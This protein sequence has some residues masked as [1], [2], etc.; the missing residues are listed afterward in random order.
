[1]HCKYC[2]TSIPSTTKWC[3]NGGS[4]ARSEQ[5][6]FLKDFNKNSGWD[7]YSNKNTSM[8]KREKATEIKNKIGI[9]LVPLIILILVI[10]ALLKVIGN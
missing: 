8:Y 9:I 3:P 1:M 2:G 5:I 6:E 4:R 7:K 10:I